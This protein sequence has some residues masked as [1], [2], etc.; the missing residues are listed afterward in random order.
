MINQVP[1]NINLVR[2]DEITAAAL[3]TI[4]QQAVVSVNNL[5]GPNIATLTTAQFY[6]N[7]NDLY[8]ANYCGKMIEDNTRHNEV[9]HAVNKLTIEANKLMEKI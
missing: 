7:T 8:F 3:T 5:I 9:D 4:F 2:G 1:A 6:D